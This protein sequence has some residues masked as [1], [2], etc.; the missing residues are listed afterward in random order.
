MNTKRKNLLRVL[1]R[2]MLVV[3]LVIASAAEAQNVSITDYKV[4][5]ESGG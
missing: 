5:G 3:L 4:P 2:S 1:A